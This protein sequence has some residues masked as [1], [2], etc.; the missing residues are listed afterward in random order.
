MR[1]Y[2]KLGL[3]VAVAVTA[4]AAGNST[5][6]A[7]R[8][9]SIGRCESNVEGTGTGTG[10]MGRGTARARAAARADWE[11]NAASAYGP[12]Y[13]RL[14]YARNVRWD[15]TRRAV[16]RAKCVVTASPCGRRIHG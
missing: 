9:N 16:L 8:W 4:Y 7:Q 2:L 14:S 5:A 1:S 15:C 10:V 11:A 13:A 6:D 3:A 12:A